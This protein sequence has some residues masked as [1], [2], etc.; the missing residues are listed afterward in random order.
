MKRAA[1]KIFCAVL[2][3]SL[4][5]CASKKIPHFIIPDYG[6]NAVRLV[7]VL[8]VK[9]QSAD[10]KAAEILREKIINELFFKGYPRI[11]QQVIDERLSKIMD[12]KAGISGSNDTL[13]T[14]G[15]LLGV[16]A[17]M[18]CTLL[19]SKTSY[20]LFYAPTRVS[21]A[22]SLISAKTGETIWSTCYEAVMRSFGIS[23]K[24][25]EMQSSQVYEP[26][27]YEVVDKAMQTLPDNF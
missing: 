18:H 26:A 10:A 20:A 25:L 1:V 21:A 11:P 9:N 19:E 12:V 23:R 7:A 4:I 2:I 13:R 16:D 22:F 3:F 5:A 24:Q 27:I 6:K 14:I 8:P 17:V 15:E